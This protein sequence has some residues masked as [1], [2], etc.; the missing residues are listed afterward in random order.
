MDDYLRAQFSGQFGS[1]GDGAE[2][3]L[4]PALAVAAEWTVEGRDRQRVAVHE[5]AQVVGLTRVPAVINH[6]FDTVKAG[7]G[8]QRKDAVDTV[9]VE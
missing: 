5:L 9:V 8:R 7:F 2:L 1:A 6:H 3:G 4:A